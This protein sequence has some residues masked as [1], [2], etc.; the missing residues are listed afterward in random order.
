MKQIIH[1]LSPHVGFPPSALLF[2]WLD[3][4]ARVTQ[5]A[6]LFDYLMML[7]HPAHSDIA[8]V[9]PSLC[10]AQPCY[11]MDCKMPGFPDL[12]YLPEFAQ[13]HVHGV[14]DAIQT[15]SSSVTSFSFCPLSSPASG[16]FPVGQLFTSGG[17][18]HSSSASV[19]PVS[20]QGWFPLGLT[21]GEWD[22]C[23]WKS[24]QIRVCLVRASSTF[25]LSYSW[26]HSLLI[27]IS[28]MACIPGPKA[29]VS[30]V[31]SLESH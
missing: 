6:E 3:F 24:P 19:L 5:F 21:L 29:S 10:H 22:Q 31:L 23:W 20:M 12:H 16:S 15:I 27:Q 28:L 26:L 30:V 9:V 14:Y 18:S 13:I 11:P 17:S 4:Q 1:T 2:S 8:V 25:Q 7:H